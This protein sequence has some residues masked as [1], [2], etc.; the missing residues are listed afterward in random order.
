VRIPNWGARLPCQGAAFLQPAK[1]LSA[2]SV[3]TAIGHDQDKVAGLRFSGKIFADLVRG[4]KSLG[5]P[6]CRAD[7]FEDSR[8]GQS[9]RIVEK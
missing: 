5:F 7:R 3:K 9:F 4:F 8:R 2:E 6:A 1:Q